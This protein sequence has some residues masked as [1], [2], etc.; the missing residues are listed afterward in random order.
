MSLLMKTEKDAEIEKLRKENTMLKDKLTLERDSSERKD[1]IISAQK[2]KII[3]LER[4]LKVHE[5]AHTPPSALIKTKTKGKGKKKG[6]DKKKSGRK[7]GAQP[8]H[9]GKSRRRKPDK[10]EHCACLLRACNACGSG[11]VQ[12]ECDTKTITEVQPRPK[13]V[14]TEYVIT[15]THCGECGESYYPDLPEEVPR[16]STYGKEV[17]IM[18]ADGFIL[19]LPFKLIR[20]QMKNAFGLDISDGTAFNLVKDAGM[21]LIERARDIQNVM[22]AAM[23]VHVDETSFSFNGKKV[24]VWI[25]LDPKSK[26]VYY[27][28]EASRGRNVIKR[29]LGPD[30][31]GI[32]ICDGYRVYASY[33]HQRCWAHLI[34]DVE[35]VADDDARGAEALAKLKEI[36]N[37][38]KEAGGTADERRRLAAKLEKRLM[39]LVKKYDD[40]T[41]LG[42]AFATV[43]RAAGSAFRYVTNEDVDSTNNAAERG[44]REIVVHRKMRGSMRSEKTFVWMASLFTHVE[45]CNA[46]GLDWRE[47]LRAYL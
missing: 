11:S 4:R 40:D 45:T 26:C 21:C 36:H 7:R 10:I 3:D 43:G 33:T 29:V 24:W 15:S 37:I 5:N 32:I 12:Y 20:K 47:E 44:L 42:K 38:G 8:G 18:C 46:T 19:R 25:F 16:S 13:P 27:H 31:D 2:I 30:W 41:P 14:T 6:K 1:G 28:I 22:R 39:K 34:R 23:V 9:K 35:T 17:K